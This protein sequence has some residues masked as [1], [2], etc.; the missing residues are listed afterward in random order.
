[1]TNNELIEMIDWCRKKLKNEKEKPLG[2][3]LTSKELNGYEQAMK[4]VMSY[5]HSKKSGENDGYQ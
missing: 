4:A 5:L 3:R 1:M 2:L